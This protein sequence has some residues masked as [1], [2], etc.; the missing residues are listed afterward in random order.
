MRPMDKI[1][2]LLP[3]LS[4]S[5]R[6]ELTT[7]LKLF[8]LDDPNQLG[9][10]LEIR[11]PVDADDPTFVAESLISYMWSAGHEFP[12]LP[13]LRRHRVYPAFRDVKV[14]PMMQFVREHAKCRIHQQQLIRIGYK[15]LF[16][17]LAQQQLAP[18][19]ITLLNHTHR[20]PAAINAAFPGYAE[21]GLLARVLTGFGST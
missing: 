21:A 15:Q 19:S 16:A 4:A 5:E 13:I 6:A 14:P 18:S 12:E 8:G 7:R 10:P 17:Q 9:L 3:S 20:L 1:V 11:K 2:E